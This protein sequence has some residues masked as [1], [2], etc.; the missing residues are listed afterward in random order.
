[1]R[2][3]ESRLRNA[4]R[5]I[6]VENE[7]HYEKLGKLMHS[8]LRNPEG[9]LQGFQLGVD[10]GYI[11]VLKHLPAGSFQNNLEQITVKIPYAISK[12]FYSEIHR[13]RRHRNL[14]FWFV[15]E[16]GG[17]ITVIFS[18]ENDPN[19]VHSTSDEV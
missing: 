17:V 18:D 8:P 11:E 16:A 2:I 12:H 3:T 19:Y 15:Q 13:V 6:L 1:M 5:R 9:W 4:I 7:G 14:G 10:A